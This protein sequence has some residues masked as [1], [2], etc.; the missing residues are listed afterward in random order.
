[1]IFLVYCRTPISANLQRSGT[2]IT[3]IFPIL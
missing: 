1:M 2:Q 3:A